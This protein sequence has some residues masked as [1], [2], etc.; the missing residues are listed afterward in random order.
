M[1]KYET[2][3]KAWRPGVR[4]LYSKLI[5]HLPTE[6][7]GFLAGKLLRYWHA[8]FFF[9][10]FFMIISLINGREAGGFA[11]RQPL[12]I[13]VW[14]QSRAA[15]RDHSPAQTILIKCFGNHWTLRG[16]CKRLIFKFFSTWNKGLVCGCI[17]IFIERKVGWNGAIYGGK[18]AVPWVSGR[19]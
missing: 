3:R 11:G 16:V 14:R 7:A 15:S 12:K 13:L 5:Y 6:L 8:V 4:K 2:R 9:G 19:G 17:F 18:R 10:F 1:Y